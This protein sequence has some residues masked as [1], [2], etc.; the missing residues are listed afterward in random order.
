MCGIKT[1]FRCVRDGCASTLS[2]GHAHVHTR[3]LAPIPAHAR[4]TCT[5]TCNTHTRAAR[6]H[7]RR[8]RHRGHEQ[9]FGGS[10]ASS[11]DNPT[12]RLFF[13]NKSLI[14]VAL[15]SLIQR[16]FRQLSSSACSK[17]EA[18]LNRAPAKHRL[19]CGLLLY[20]FFSGVEG[21]DASLQLFTMW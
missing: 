12:L 8:H 21:G 4:T 6:A 14:M 2:Q 19:T 11:A 15:G 16:K 7:D 13:R 10:N 17:I 1:N 9:N 20:Y 5:H 3:A 18:V